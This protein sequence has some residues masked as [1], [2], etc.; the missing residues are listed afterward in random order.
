MTYLSSALIVGVK[1]LGVF[2]HGPE[3]RRLVFCAT[4][5]ETIFEAATQLGLLVRI[6]M[7]SGIGSSASRLS[8]VSSIVVIGK[9]GVQ[10]FLKR[11]SEKL[12]KTSVLGNICV[13]TSV[14]PVF[15]LTAVFKIGAGASNH[16]WNEK[17]KMVAIL[18]ALGLPNLVI[19]FFKMCNLRRKLTTANMSQGII[20]DFLSLHLWPK[21]R[22]GKKIVLAMTIF[23]FLYVSPLPLAISNPQPK[24]Q[25][26]AEYHN[27]EY[28][29][30]ESETGNRVL[31]ASICFLV[32]G[33]LAFVLVICM[34][35]FE[36]KWVEK[37]V[38]KFPKHS[39][40]EARGAS[41]ELPAIEIDLRNST[42]RNKDQNADSMK[43]DLFSTLPTK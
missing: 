25:W 5:D 27:T 36:D 15:L 28:S 1:C 9:V 31:V 8:A 10:N 19:L 24:T 39:K 35:L 41:K 38:A 42:S 22:Y 17:T 37:I 29:E 2:C 30:Y 3:T 6:F 4:K 18:V 12:S 26:T 13:A 40:V 34:I 43:N 14:L 20:A 33:F 23:S 11:H 32:I 7:S 16:V 21:D